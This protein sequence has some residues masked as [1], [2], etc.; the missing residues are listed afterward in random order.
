MPVQQDHRKWAVRYNTVPCAVRRSAPRRHNIARQKGKSKPLYV[1]FLAQSPPS[2]RARVDTWVKRDDGFLFGRVGR[3]NAQVNERA[4]LGQQLTNHLVDDLLFEIELFL[5]LDLR[6]PLLQIPR[7]HL[8]PSHASAS[9]A[10]TPLV[11][12][13][14]ASCHDPILFTLVQ[15]ATNHGRNFLELLV[16]D[17]EVLAFLVR[18]V[19]LTPLPFAAAAAAAAPP[20]SDGSSLVEAPDGCWPPPLFL[21]HVPVCHE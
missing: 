16:G 2:Q 17:G 6:K 1:A 4:A 11:A 10:T 12:L 5:R 18:R 19:A 20:S 13:L 9:A 14:F 21:P 15:I 3:R 7:H 8:I